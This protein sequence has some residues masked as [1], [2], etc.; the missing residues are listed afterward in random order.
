M[1]DRKP[2]FFAEQKRLRAWF[3]KNHDTK[4]EQWIGFYKKSTG[5]KSITWPQSVDEALCFGWIDGIRKSI[6][7]QSY[8]IRF[9]PLERLF[10][11]KKIEKIVVKSPFVPR[12]FEPPLESAAS[13]RLISCSRIGK[14]IVWQLESDVR[15]VFHLMITGRF[16]WKA[17]STRMPKSK[18]DLIAFQF[19]H[20]TLMMTEAGK[21]KRASLHVIASD[22][23]MA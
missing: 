9:T 2:K 10:K 13:Q 15:L 11:G 18:T 19:E 6:D 14:R 4:S 22:G 21:K 1:S 12:T 23:D 3:I 16:H 5:K 20:G 8:M 17:G 7:D